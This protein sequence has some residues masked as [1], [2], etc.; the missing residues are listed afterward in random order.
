MLLNLEAIQKA[1]LV[2]D[3]F[4][5]LIARDVLTR[6][7]KQTL[8][9]DFPRISKPGSFPVS[10]LDYGPTF[11]SLVA[12]LRGPELEAA[13]SE[14]FGMDLSARP[15][16][17]TIRGRSRKKDGQIHPDSASKL[18]TVLVYMNDSWKSEGGRLRL[19]RSKDDLEDMVAEVPPD[20]GTLL[21]FR[22]ADNSFHGHKPFE[23]ERRTIQM[24]WVTEQR[25]VD[26]ELA[27][28]KSSA[29][30]KRLIPFA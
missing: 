9:A 11:E 1:A 27:R 10:E 28:H 23:G 3:P 26:R 24:N 19:L 14:K 13:M 30:I 22:R 12:E 15:S 5:F 6:E 2:R 16:M 4:H 25:V 29:R 17:I 8:D 18:I 20:W 21:A 7:S